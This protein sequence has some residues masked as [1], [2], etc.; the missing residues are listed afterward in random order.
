MLEQ[1]SLSP[2]SNLDPITNPAVVD[3]PY[4]SDSDSVVATSDSASDDSSNA[5]SAID[6]RFL[7]YIHAKHPLYMPLAYP[8]FFSTSDYRY[9]R[10]LKLKG[11][12]K[13]SSA[14]RYLNITPAI[15][16]R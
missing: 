6:A 11:K 15:Y 12:T 16:Y 13:D 2:A 1:G 5:A 8:I 9:H 3:N 7:S 14:R 4:D 10:Y